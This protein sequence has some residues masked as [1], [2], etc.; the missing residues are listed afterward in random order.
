MACWGIDP[1]VRKGFSNV[2]VE[3]DIDTECDD[4]QQDA[5]M[6]TATKYSVVFDMLVNRHRGQRLPQLKRRSVSGHEGP[7]RDRK[8]PLPVSGLSAHRSNR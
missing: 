1:D 5:L 4:D 8:G 3:F 6:A 7:F 2:E